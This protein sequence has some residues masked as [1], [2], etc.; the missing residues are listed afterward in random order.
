MLPSIL[1]EQEAAQS[2]RI[3]VNTLR[4]AR[5]RG[6]IEGFRQGNGW[7]YTMRQIET[8]IKRQEGTLCDDNQDSS[9]CG[10]NPASENHPTGTFTTMKMAEANAIRRG[11]ELARKTMKPA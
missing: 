1:T 8:Y 5:R 6:K 11:L 9:N 10:T 7:F 2:L 3:Q 4:N